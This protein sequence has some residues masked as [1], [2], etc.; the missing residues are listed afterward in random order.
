M[1]AE[2]IN[3]ANPTLATYAKQDGVHLRIAAKA[4]SREVANA[5]IEDFEVKVRKLA[6]RYVYGVG[7]ETLAG[8]IG[9]MM[10]RHGLSVATMESASGG[11]LAS[12]VTD[13]PGSSEWFRGGVVAYT[14]ALK[15]ASGVDADVVERHGTV[16][17]ETTGCRRGI[18]H[19]RSRRAERDRREAGWNGPHR[20]GPS[21]RDA[22]DEHAVVDDARGVQAARRIRRVEPALACA[23]EA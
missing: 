14:G 23:Q 13:T 1:V 5:M 6:G 21:G 4:E 12:Y 19:H 20:P 8:A 11:L 17:P 3:S 16:A 2:L 22:C 7:E 9:E 15:V 18:G 10:V